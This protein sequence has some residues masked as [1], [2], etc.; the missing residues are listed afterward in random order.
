MRRTGGCVLR[1][2][3]EQ[4]TLQEERLAEDLRFPLGKRR[5]LRFGHANPQHLSRVVPLVEGRQ[6]VE[7][8][9]ALQPDE[10]GV[11]HLGQHLRAFGF[12]DT[13]RALDEK[14]LVEGENQLQGSRERIVDEKSSRSEPFPDGSS[15]H[16]AGEAR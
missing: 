4:R 10:A 16:H 5:A 14:R 13:G 2:G 1:D 8:F 12:A 3:L 9:V 7:A 11:E 15:V 6:G